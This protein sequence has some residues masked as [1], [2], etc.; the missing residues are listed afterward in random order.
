MIVNE[1]DPYLSHY[2]IRRKSGRFPWG[3]GVDP[4]TGM[5]YGSAGTN[6]SV[7]RAR[8]FNEAIQALRDKGL[9][10][11][12]I[13]KGFDMATKDL[14]QRGD[15]D[16]NSSAFR[17]NKT[18]A[19]AEIKAADIATAQ[20]LK[21][22]KQMS[23]IA[24]GEQMGINESSVRALLAP[25]AS[26]RSDKLTA[27]T[28]MLRDMV[29]EAAKQN[30]GIG[31]IDVGTGVN[32]HMGISVEHMKTTLALLKEEGY[33][34]DKTQLD[35]PGPA[36]NKTLTRVV[37][38]KGLTYRDIK[39]NQDKI[40]PIDQ[41]KRSGDGGRSFYGLLPPISVSTKRVAVN[42]AE[43][44]GKEADGVM[45]IRPG[46]KDLSMGKSR[47]AQVR[48]LV[49]GT[50]YLKG[51]AVY[52][53]DLPAGK[54]IVFNT[55]K[56]RA[57]IGD[58]PLKAMKKIKDDPEN[59]F[60][61]MVKQIGDTNEQGHVTKVTSA[62]NIVNKEGEWDKWKKT[63]S[64]QVLSKQ[65][66]VLAKT[67]LAMTYE[68]SKNE[69]DSILALTNPVVKK[70][71]LE[72]YADDTE[73]SSV[74]L[75]A[76]ALPR[77]RTQVIMPIKSLGDSEIHAP[78][79]RD[80]EEVALIRYP[81]GGTFEIPVLKVNNKNKEALS[82][83]GNDAADAV[84]INSKVAE[85]LSGADFDGD[86]VLVIPQTDA[87]RIKSTPALEGLKNFD[88]QRDYGPYDGMKTI[89]GGVVV[90]AKNKV[91]D[92]GIDPK[93]GGPKKPSSKLKGT[94]MGKV[95]NLITDMTIKRANTTELAAAVRHSMVVIDAEKHSLNYKQSFI[96]NNIKSLYIKYQPREDE[97][98]IGG[99]S[100]LVSQATS[101]KDVPERRDRKPSDIPVAKKMKSEGRS[102]A[103]IAE[104]LGITEASAKTLLVPGAKG[105]KVDP[106][107]GKKVY[108][109][110]GASYVDSKTGKTI[111]KTTASVKLKEVED[112]RD[113]SSGTVIEKVYAE[114]SNKLKNLSNIA[115]RE[116]VNIDVGKADPAVKDAF[117]SEIQSLN[118]KLNLIERNRP[119][120]RQALV[121]QN[122]QVALRKEE[123]PSMDKAE[124]RK[125]ERQT[126]EEARRRVGAERLKVMI[127]P[128]E[129]SAIQAGA[130]SPSKLT[131]I[132][133]KADID[134]VKELATPRAKL[135]VT[136]A[137]RARAEQMLNQGY[138][139]SQVADALG[140]SLS[141]LKADLNGDG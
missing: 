54:D 31:I 41:L 120:E 33:T 3:S 24:I 111:F 27:T 97:R 40:V 67:Q 78:N 96:D 63:I 38:A 118:A 62:L 109:E 53:D 114:H 30:D 137:K 135:L 9:S 10:D 69:L 90:D 68:R 36:G 75:K 84:G 29:D 57:K 34:V 100:T 122:A 52:K 134:N 45:Y 89:D 2:G 103:E 11:S 130:I 44:G 106:T 58:D 19:N 28:N 116:A 71:L 48:I 101:K 94:E 64:T 59:P 46:V 73:K 61:S 110:T 85:R 16:F 131:Q 83:L 125:L 12:E 87:G 88:A 138:T 66:P 4:K 47:Y 136:P 123:N 99:A 13:A 14:Q 77:Q 6:S 21:Y 70:K 79:F 95:S 119:L 39:M 50:H 42:Y 113:L 76:T 126:L 102:T 22:D 72:T 105:G 17:A 8:S 1:D 56:E 25:G 98:T 115:R 43:D 108:L 49:N 127:T 23:N 5:N 107:T 117:K 51:M 7:N 82:V 141:T 81:H 55:N 121:I 60:G 128:Q 65:S 35:Q 32:T 37:A 132:L 26:D 86:T 133:D 15:P 20:K 140:I 91:V 93:T 18:I 112:A 139:Q 92:Y 74:Q 104:R 129:W 80:G 124:L